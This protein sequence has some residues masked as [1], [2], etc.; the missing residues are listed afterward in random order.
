MKCQVAMII[1][2]VSL[3]LPLSTD[4]ARHRKHSAGESLG[5][6]SG[7]VYRNGSIPVRRAIVRLRNASVTH[8]HRRHSAHRA[9][10]GRTGG[11]TIK[12]PA[13]GYTITASKRHVG[14]ARSFVRLTAGQTVSNIKLFLGRSKLR[15][16]L[17]HRIHVPVTSPP[18][19]PQPQHWPQHPVAPSAPQRIAPGAPGRIHG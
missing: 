3:L 4:A 11:F 9:H 15:V 1:L 12:A 5:T 17:H 14:A 10:T 19:T 2:A 18:Q 8:H 13:G 16:P 7:T 6:A